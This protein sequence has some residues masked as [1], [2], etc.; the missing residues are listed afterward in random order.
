MATLSS[1]GRF[2]AGEACAD[3]DILYGPYATIAAAHAALLNAEQ[4]V[5]GRTVGIQTGNT[6]EEY[7]YQGGTTEQHLVKKQVAAQEETDPTV[8]SWAKQQNKPSYDYSEIG[9]TP[10]LGG[11][12]TKSVNDL[13]NYY[14]KSET[15]TKAEVASLIGAI[16]QF[17]YEIY[18]TLPQTGQSNVL[19]LIGPTGSGSD[20]YE[21]YVYAN[22]AFTKIGDTSIDLSGYV[23]TSALNT[24]LADY[25]TTSNLTALLSNK[26]DKVS[27]ATN[28]NFAGL[29]A[30]GNLTDSGKKASDFATSAQGAKAD[31]AVQ[32]VT[33]GTTTTGA[34]GTDA[35]VTNSGTATNPVLEFTIPRGAN[36]QDGA[37]AYNPFKG[38]YLITDTLPSTGQ[39]GDYIYVVDSQTPPVTH[40]YTWDGSAFADSGE[41]VTFGNAQFANSTKLISQTNIVNNLNTGGVDDVL[42]AEQGRIAGAG[43]A[44]A[45]YNNS[46]IG[47]ISINGNIKNTSQGGHYNYEFNVK[48]NEVYLIKTSTLINTGICVFKDAN[49]NT[50]TDTVV[51]NTDG[52]G[53]SN[54]IVSVPY[55]A[56][57]MV[58]CNLPSFT[59][60]T[61]KKTNT[62]NNNISSTTSI[63]NIVPIAVGDSMN[64]AVLKLDS[65]ISTGLIDNPT[66]ITESGKEHEYI[67][68]ST[69]NIAVSSNPDNSRNLFTYEV[70]EGQIWFV[71]M[72]CL[73]TVAANVAFYNSATIGADSY[74]KEYSIQSPGYVDKHYILNIP[75][76]AVRMCISNG[77][78]TTLYRVR[79]SEQGAINYYNELHTEIQD[80]ETQTTNG[81]LAY[82]VLEC[83]YLATGEPIQ[84]DLYAN[85]YLKVNRNIEADS[86][87]RNYWNI[88]ACPASNEDRW[89]RIDQFI[90]GFS[91][92]PV[93][94][95]FLVDNA[96]Q[97][98]AGTTIPSSDIL[99]TPSTVESNTTKTVNQ[100]VFVPSGK[101]LCLTQSN[102][103]STSYC[104]L[105]NTVL[106]STVI[107]DMQNDIQDLQDNIDETIENTI[108]NKLGV[109]AI[110]D[111]EN[112]LAVIKET[113]GYT[114][115]FRR[116][117]VIGGSMSSGV[118]SSNEGTQPLDPSAYAY[119]SLQFMARLCGAEGFNFSVGGMSA[120]NWNT[121]TS[122][123]GASDLFNN[124]PVQMYLIQLGNNDV[125]YVDPSSSNYDST[126][127]MG[128][129]SDVAGNNGV[130]ANT[131]Y[132]KMGEIL[133][134]I[135]RVQPRAYVFLSTFLKGYGTIPPS[136]APDFDYNQAIRNI[137]EYYTANDGANRPEGDEL[138]YYLID[139]YTYGKPYSYYY[140]GIHTGT[141]RGSHLVA[142]GYL[143][144]A[145]Q[146]CTYIDWII[147]NNMSDF[148]DVAFVGS[149]RYWV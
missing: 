23:T 82:N 70:N 24:A 20:R 131:F 81:N 105:Y 55:N 140:Q 72:H 69:G 115:I 60:F 19:Y 54:A 71:D 116:M 59:A 67:I 118:H 100:S 36:G 65:K 123:G 111:A 129:V 85:L 121:N 130:F 104:R 73:G 125:Q 86:Q 84:L 49:G 106:G 47:Y 142:T 51:V 126:Y 110:P 57:K 18:S 52:T 6:I 87:Q 26:A 28:G 42:S 92:L 91:S 29:D 99:I 40:L 45:T 136:F 62:N 10:D 146:Y 149:D 90:G 37:D 122:I 34:A 58:V 109:D 39:S 120:H 21:E 124:N 145:Y 38:T 63:K 74:M 80:L 96:S 46:S 147:K 9:N 103:I 79:Y 78:V 141:T 1:T 107:N 68:Y 3:N 95:A 127:S 50:L 16:Q 137:V 133:Q 35:S 30:N 88:Y 4:N 148:N 114:A 66:S 31:T 64:T 43:W 53:E 97:I 139:Y 22:N 17:H 32:Q 33:V 15:Y 41:T 117:G 134:N 113:A 5:V 101:I 2:A 14:L 143:L 12:V 8:P 112:P 83:D 27:N 132:G 94:G 61:V 89:L 44:V 138:H 48:Y 77:Y 108:D 56:T 7:W 13:T 102:Y 119:S 75:K 144:W 93:G 128:N 98:A 25:T 11:F 76:G 135:R